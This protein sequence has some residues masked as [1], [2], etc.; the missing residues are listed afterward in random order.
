MTSGEG[1]KGAGTPWVT[2]GPFLQ[3]SLQQILNQ[4]G[5]NRQIPSYF[6]SPGSPEL[7]K[8]R[9]PQCTGTSFFKSSP[10]GF[11]LISLGLWKLVVYHPWEQIKSLN[12]LHECL[13]APLWLSL[14]SHRKDCNGNC[15]GW[16]RELVACSFTDWVKIHNNPIGVCSTHT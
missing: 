7:E 12:S 2:Q 15:Q 13:V 14:C 8:G 10:G 16:G 1:R 11:W 5:E 6:M 4:E 9:V 3:H